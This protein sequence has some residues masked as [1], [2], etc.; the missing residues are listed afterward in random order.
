MKKSFA[1][2]LLFVFTLFLLMPGCSN[3]DDDA[4]FEEYTNPVAG[5]PVNTEEW[6]IQEKNTI[7]EQMHGLEEIYRQ[8]LSYSSRFIESSIELFNMDGTD[9]YFVTYEYHSEK[10]PWIICI[11]NSEGELHIGVPGDS[12]PKETAAE[13][14]KF[15][16]EASY[17]YPL[18]RYRFIK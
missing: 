13:Y 12:V 3:D 6:L 10:H 2:Y 17:K 14:D 16:K 18:W 1:V 7:K 11:Y 8:Q 15:T 4:A 9:Y 5:N